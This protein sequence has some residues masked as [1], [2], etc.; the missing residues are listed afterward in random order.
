MQNSYYKLRTLN[1][2]AYTLYILY[3][4]FAYTLYE[5]LHTPLY[6][7]SAYTLYKKF[8][9]TLYENF[10]YTLYEKSAYMKNLAIGGLQIKLTLRLQHNNNKKELLPLGVWRPPARRRHRGRL[11]LGSRLLGEAQQIEFAYCLIP[12][13]FLTSVYIILLVGK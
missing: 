10:A 9:Y 2:H 7:K 13:R 11:G 8:A 3:E 6:E 4:K 12:Q 5:N 1:L